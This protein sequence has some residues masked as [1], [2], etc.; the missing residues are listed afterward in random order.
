ML[1][2]H[3]F[4]FIQDE[5]LKYIHNTLYM[6][7]ADCYILAKQLKREID[8]NSSKYFSAIDFFENSDPEKSLYLN[9][10]RIIKYPYDYGVKDDYYLFSVKLYDFINKNFRIAPHIVKKVV[11]SD[12]NGFYSDQFVGIYFKNN[13]HSIDK[14]KTLYY[15]ERN[16]E[17]IVPTNFVFNSYINSFDIFELSETFFS[18][19]LVVNE[20][21]KN[22]LLK[23]S[24]TGFK[25]IDINSLKN[26]E[27]KRTGRK[28]YPKDYKK[29]LP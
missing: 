22:N 12:K 18:F 1:E 6:F 8:N 10:Y 21:L 16:T 19:T 13:F 29:N 23:Q 26:Y 5:E 17:L 20:N 15:V 4:A 3:F 11:V 28:L 24:F 7:S 9:A 2:N 14:E 27:E 25:I